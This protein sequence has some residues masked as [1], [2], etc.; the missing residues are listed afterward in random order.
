MSNRVSWRIITHRLSRPGSRAVSFAYRN[1]STAVI[2][3]T[4]CFVIATSCPKGREHSMRPWQSHSLYRRSPRRVAPRDDT[5]RHNAPASPLSFRAHQGEES[6][7]KISPRFTPRNDI[8]SAFA[9]LS[10]SLCELFLNLSIT[11]HPVGRITKPNNTRRSSPCTWR[12]HWREQ[13]RN[14]NL[15]LIFPPINTIHFV[16]D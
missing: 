2:S 4:T 13:R 7:F 1:V 12:G 10:F 8:P 6:C 9:L 14:M 11:E 3:L 16:I 5:F 15:I